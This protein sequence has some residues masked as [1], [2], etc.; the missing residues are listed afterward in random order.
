MIVAGVPAR[1]VELRFPDT[2]SSHMALVQFPQNANTLEGAGGPVG[3]N[4]LLLFLGCSSLS[5]RPEKYAVLNFPSFANPSLA[6]SCLL[7]TIVTVLLRACSACA[8][9]LLDLV[10]FCLS[11]SPFGTRARRETCWNVSSRQAYI[12]VV[13]FDFNPLVRDVVQPK[14][15]ATIGWFNGSGRIKA[16][17]GFGKSARP[18]IQ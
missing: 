6:I 4:W 14:K 3:R 10:S 7:V 1:L 11:Y 16:A 15:G 18:L 9:C 12:Y 5:S 2:V 13:A 17:I 8:A